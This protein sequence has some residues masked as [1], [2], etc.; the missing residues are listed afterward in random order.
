[1]QAP[2]DFLV[3]LLHPQLLR[4]VRE[5]AGGAPPAAAAAACGGDAGGGSD[6]GGGG[7]GGGS[8]RAESPLLGDESL[9]DA[10]SM[11]PRSDWLPLAGARASAARKAARAYVAIARRWSASA[12][13]A[14]EGG[15]SES[16]EEEGDVFHRSG[17]WE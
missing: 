8:F 2:E 6:E 11:G 9:W 5:A 15:E 4:L 12:A 3:K 17:I 7:G 10:A 13:A 14:A 1:L 16:G